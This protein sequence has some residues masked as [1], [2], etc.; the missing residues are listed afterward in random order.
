MDAEDF[1]SFRKRIGI[2]KI[3]Q[4]IGDDSEIEYVALQDSIGIMAASS[5]V[6]ELVVFQMI[7][8]Y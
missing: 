5:T 2:G 6:K 1:L 8:F 7:S 3:I 4:E